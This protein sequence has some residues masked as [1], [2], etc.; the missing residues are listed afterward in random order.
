MELVSEET[1]VAL[2]EKAPQDYRDKDGDR[3]P[4]QRTVII[5]GIDENPLVSSPTSFS[6]ETTGADL[7]IPSR[8][9]GTHYPDLSW[10]RS[11]FISPFTTPIRGTNCRLYFVAGPRVLTFLASSHQVARNS[12]LEAGCNPLDLADRVNGMVSSLAELKRREKRMKEELAGHVAK[13][14]W[15]S[16][17]MSTEE[18]VLAGL[19][20]R[21]EEATNSLDFLSLVSMDLSARYNALDE[22]RRKYLFLLAVGDTP[23]STNPTNGAV[24]ILGSEDLV[25]KAGKLTVE[26]LAGKIKGGGKGRWQGKLTDKWVAGDREKLERVLTDSI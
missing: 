3:V 6:G 2:N 18:D 25:V 1:G 19:S 9:C 11:L 13:E 23:G 15:E 10:L 26:K 24:L 20:F 7:R 17:I 8:C 4:V 14:L 22:P 16:A 12:A 21:E 5:D